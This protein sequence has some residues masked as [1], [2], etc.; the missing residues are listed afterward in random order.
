MIR[1]AVCMYLRMD[2]GFRSVVNGLVLF[3]E[4]LDGA[5]GDIPCAQSVEDW[6]LKAGIVEYL[7]S[8]KKFVGKEYAIIVD[9]SITVGSQKLLL[10]LAAPARHE[11]RALKHE[12]IDVLAMAVS[13]SW[14]AGDVDMEI[15]KLADKIG[16]LPEYMVSDNG[17]NLRK[18][19]EL[20][21]V[22]RHRDIS[23]TIGLILEKEYKD[24][25]DYKEFMETMNKKRLKYQLT[26]NAYLLPPKLRTISRFMNMSKWVEWGWLVLFAYE[27]LDEKQ[28]A[29][30]K[31]VLKYRALITELHH[32]M[33]TIDG[34]FTKVKKEGLS[35]AT[36]RYCDDY[37]WMNLL[38]K[39][40]NA[41]GCKRVG[42]AIRRYINEEKRLLKA[43]D[44]CHNITSDIIESTFGVYKNIQPKNKFSGITPII[45][46][47]PIYGKARDKKARKEID[48]KGKMEATRIEDIKDWKKM[49]LLDN[50]QVR[51]TI[52]LRKAKKKVG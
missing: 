14:K 31:F 38:S 27:G 51:R 47:L 23:H 3:N 46:A 19:A 32:V 22:P 48:F 35:Y 49:T 12:D 29:A 16:H 28:Q 8:C 36:A 43:K 45:L 30:Y 39:P 5:M 4:F 44:D 50:W 41:D 9:E 25:P 24:R 6:L 13:P 11:G 15:R 21:G 42:H 33:E 2:C 17:H 26:E 37:I 1:L 18:G 10:I 52:D 7:D 34:V 20:A 40:E